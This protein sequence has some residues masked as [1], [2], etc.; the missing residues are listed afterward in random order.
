[1]GRVERKTRFLSRFEESVQEEAVQA[2]SKIRF[3]R[4]HLMEAQKEETVWNLGFGVCSWHEESVPE[5]K[6]FLEME[7]EEALISEDLEKVRSSLLSR[8]ENPVPKRVA[9]SIQETEGVVF[10]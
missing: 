1:M 9:S 3:E 7:K 5:R 10:F 6:C 8:D 4:N 2:Q